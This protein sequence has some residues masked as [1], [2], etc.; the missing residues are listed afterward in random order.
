MIYKIE[1]F[2]ELE[3]GFPFA[4]FTDD[5][6]NKIDYLEQTGIDLEETSCISI[7]MYTHAYIDYLTKLFSKYDIPLKVTDVTA[8]YTHTQSTFDEFTNKY[9]SQLD[10]IEEFT[11]EEKINLLNK[12]SIAESYEYLCLFLINKLTIFYEK[13]LFF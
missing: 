1:R 9:I 6:W 11:Q 10:K 3:V 7:G 8:Q 13:Q 2:K 12:I 4:R 5:E